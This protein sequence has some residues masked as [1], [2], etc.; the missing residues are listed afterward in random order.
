MNK[1]SIDIQSLVLY[2][3]YQISSKM[4]TASSVKF[5]KSS[6]FYILKKYYPY[7]NWKK[8]IL[9]IWKVHSVFVVVVV[10]INC[11]HFAKQCNS[12]CEIWH[13]LRPPFMGC[14]RALPST[15]KPQRSTVHQNKPLHTFLTELSFDRTLKDIS[16]PLNN[17]SFGAI[18][19]LNWSTIRAGKSF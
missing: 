17:A 8:V 1:G 7:K 2:I 11:F 14:F 9:A 18:L 12:L 10:L 15:Y 4:T 19:K 6:N 13:L 3:A 16:R 5:F